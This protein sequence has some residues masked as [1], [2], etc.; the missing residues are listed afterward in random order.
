MNDPVNSPAHYLRFG[1]VEPIEIE[2]RLTYCRGT[3]VKYII[4]AG[5]KDKSREIED[6]KKA[7]WMIDREIARL[8]KDAACL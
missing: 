7:R 8:E 2:E 4:R 1:G 6:L 3:A 5:Y